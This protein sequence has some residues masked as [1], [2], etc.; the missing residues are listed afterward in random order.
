MLRLNPMDLGMLL[1][2]SVIT[3]CIFE[4]TQQA[5]YSMHRAKLSCKT[6]VMQAE[7]QIL[8]VNKSSSIL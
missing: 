3:V 1:S 8:D 2:R 6:P 5:A 7:L 4:Q